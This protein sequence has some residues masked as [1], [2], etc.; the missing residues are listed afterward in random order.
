MMPADDE[1]P[2]LDRAMYQRAARAVL[3]HSLI[4]ERYPDS[5]TLPLVRR[6]AAPLRRDMAR[7]FDY[8]LEFTP[9][10]ARLFR[11]RDALDASR[12]AMAGTNQ[13]RPFDRRRYACLALAVA[14][15]GR[16]GPQI[17]LS[18]LAERVTAEAAR[19]DG[20]DLS[21]EDKSDRAAFV[22]AV[23]WLQTRGAVRLADGNA[24]RWA[25]DPTAGEALYDIDRDIL[26][27]VYRPTRVLQHIGSVTELLYR[28][29]AASRATRRLAAG[30][31][32]RRALVEQPVVYD[33]DLDQADRGTLRT[34]SVAAEVAELTGMII[35]R[36]AEG[37]AMVDVSGRFSDRRFPGTGT[38]AQAS[39]LLLNRIA[40]RI[41]DLDA[42]P[43]LTLPAPPPASEQLS[44]ALDS[45][46]PRTEQAEH[47]G[48]P[49][50]DL[51]DP[52]DRSDADP[53]EWA[54]P[55]A[56][57]PSYPMLE[58]S[59]LASTLADL[60]TEYGSTFRATLTADPPRL[61]AGVVGLL[62]ELHMVVRVP[63]G[64]L[65]LPLLARYR[66]AVLD[67]RRREPEGGLFDL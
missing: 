51:T 3:T 22:D 47:P 41:N 30:Q 2:A 63:G 55:A 58:D 4:T 52:P 50:P 6:W 31:R 65:A 26:R 36:R 60:L 15:L 57:P 16:S 25:V 46:L 53:E 62:T 32:V 7:L 21:A 43:L 23:S 9:T 38:I 10:T 17:A 5:Q 27:A 11:A 1:V 49:G 40:D 61:L 48:R 45:V 37:I 44:Q 67:V 13:D 12:P 18:E 66:N 34:P 28:P 8:R 24:G 56:D 14:V 59:W 33:A 35:E 39:L 42:P 29:D 20:V 19:I 54:V 64:V